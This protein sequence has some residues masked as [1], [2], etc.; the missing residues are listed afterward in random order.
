M[1]SIPTILSKF[2]YYNLTEEN[3]AGKRSEYQSGQTTKSEITD[4]LRLQGYGSEYAGYFIDGTP[5]YLGKNVE[6]DTVVFESI[7]YLSLNGK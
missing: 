1:K 4:Q 3:R 7:D 2:N 6:R 5:N